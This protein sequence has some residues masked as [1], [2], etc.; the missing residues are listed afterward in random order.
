MGLRASHAGGPML[1]AA[2]CP[3]RLLSC[4]HAVAIG[5]FAARPWLHCVIPLSQCD[6]LLLPRHAMVLPR[7]ASGRRGDAGRRPGRRTRLMPFAAPVVVE[8]CCHSFLPRWL[9]VLWFAHGCALLLP[10]FAV[11]SSADVSDVAWC[12]CRHQSH[13][14]G[15]MCPLCAT[16][17]MPLAHCC[18]RRF[19]RA[20][21]IRCLQ[22]CRR[23]MR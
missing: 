10:S 4:T 23:P 5:T 3:R 7:S 11:P 2:S 15:T 13:I 19:R 9:H 12:L 17:P 20:P 21:N 22:F 8:H 18:T 1:R 6:H 16:C 14:H